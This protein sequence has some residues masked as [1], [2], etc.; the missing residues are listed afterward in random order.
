MENGI[1]DLIVMSGMSAN[2]KES[3][4]IIAMHVLLRI[5][6]NSA[7]SAYHIKAVGTLREVTT[8]ISV[9]S[10]PF[11]PTVS[12]RSINPFWSSPSCPC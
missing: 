11:L 1:S 3:Y 10:V 5:L 2:S 9:D 12:W 6:S 4:S 8:S 7:H